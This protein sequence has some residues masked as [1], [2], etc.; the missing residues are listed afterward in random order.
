MR[1]SQSKRQQCDNN[2]WAVRYPMACPP[3]GQ[4][5]AAWS[6]P[7]VESASPA[8]RRGSVPAGA[9]QSCPERAKR[10]SRR[11][12]AARGRGDGCRAC[13]LQRA[14]EG[15]TKG[16]SD[17][18]RLQRNQATTYL[19][20]SAPAASTVRYH[21]PTNVSLAVIDSGHFVR[22]QAKFH[23]SGGLPWPRVACKKRPSGMRTW[24]TAKSVRPMPEGLWGRRTTRCRQSASTVPCR[25]LSHAH[26]PG[27]R[28]GPLLT[29]VFR[30][31]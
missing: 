16:G 19:S 26:H 17:L 21:A 2:W 7:G 11:D 10:A 29:A 18:G 6:S 8:R 13:Q 5:L 31:C 12:A 25:D 1:L 30:S 22:L 15:R 9:R 24:A 23:G 28:G 4:G 27:L 20:V 3:A 14:A